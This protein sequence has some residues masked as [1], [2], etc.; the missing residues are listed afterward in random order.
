[1]SG[2]ARTGVAR[3]G[4]MMAGVGVGIVLTGCVAAAIAPDEVASPVDV[5]AVE[6]VESVPVEVATPEPVVIDVTPSEEVAPV[7]DVPVEEVAP[8]AAS[9][10]ADGEPAAGPVDAF[11]TGVL[12]CGTGAGV[13]IDVDP[14]GNT[15]AYCEPALAE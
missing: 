15:W 14:H 11:D 12:F 2:I 8:V 7:A 6:V 5:L 4:L 3:F 1:M 9:R 10:P 13:A